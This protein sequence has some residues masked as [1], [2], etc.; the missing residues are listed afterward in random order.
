[1]QFATELIG[2]IL[3]M[4][5]SAA[6]WGVVGQNNQKKGCIHT[7]KIHTSAVGTLGIVN[8][9]NEILFWCAKCYGSDRIRIQLFF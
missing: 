3:S 8:V 4:L 2:C 7:Q 6:Q 1:M 9:T 5:F